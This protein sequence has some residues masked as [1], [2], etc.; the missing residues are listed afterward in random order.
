M[1]EVDLVHYSI[2]RSSGNVAPA[3]AGL[4]VSFS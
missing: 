3:K 2:I 1:E 4:G